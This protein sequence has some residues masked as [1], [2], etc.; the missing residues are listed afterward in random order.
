MKYLSKAIFPILILATVVSVSSCKK[1]FLDVNTDPNRVTDDN[2]TPE[3]IFTQA[4]DGVGRRQA[5]GNFSFL[6]NWLGYLSTSG[7]FAIDQTETS[8]AIDFSFGDVLWQN[9]YGV[10]FDLYLTKQKALAK[11]DSVLAGASMI[12]SAKLW[13]ELVDI[14]GNVPY[15]QA[16]HNSV[17]RAPVYDAGTAIYLDLQKVLDSAN[18]YMNATSRSTFASIDLVNHGDKT[19]WKKF[20]NTLKL[21]MLIRQSQVPSFNPATELAKLTAVGSAGFL[22]SGQTISVNPGYANEAGKQNPFYAT[23]GFTP[24]GADASTVSRANAYFVNLLTGTSDPRLYR[25]YGALGS[26]A[27]VGTTY[28][29]AAGNPTGANSS[30]FGPGLIGSATQNQWILTSVESLFLQAEAIARG[31]LTGNAQTAL[32]AAITESFIWLGVPNAAAAA[33]TY[34]GN[35]PSIT[36]VTGTVLQQAKTIAYQKYIALAAIDPQETWSD[37]RRLNMIPN[38]GY[39]S[40]N[41]SKISTSIPIRLLYPQSEYTTN[42]AN[43]NAQGTINQFTSKIF[44]QP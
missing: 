14:Y 23:Y 6:N 13:E 41:P 16:F 36:T 42:S 26:G 43:V 5:S 33:A 25:F 20:A 24:T 27:V 37:H 10:L 4:A 1:D 18:N 28:G 8:Y 40:V 21:R 7:D 29:L 15:T 17:T 44:W 3:L 30:K 34:I 9:H 31:W 22:G 12:L 2:I 38:T 19:L 35:N 32:N 39:I 11:G